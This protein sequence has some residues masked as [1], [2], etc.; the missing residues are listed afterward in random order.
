MSREGAKKI[1]REDMVLI[2]IQWFSMENLTVLVF[3]FLFFEGGTKTFKFKYINKENFDYY[4]YFTDEK[5]FAPYLLSAF[6]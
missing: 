6:A 2:G 1:R 3:S 5:L 4:P